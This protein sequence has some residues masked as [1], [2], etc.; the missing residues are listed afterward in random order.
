[1]RG[2]C[3]VCGARFRST[4]ECSRCGANLGPLMRLSARARLLRNRARLAVEAGDV[5]QARKLCRRANLL[6]ANPA[7]RSLALLAAWMDPAGGRGI[8]S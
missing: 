3:P 7:G 5:N 2:V 6:E 1:M 4:S 8:Q